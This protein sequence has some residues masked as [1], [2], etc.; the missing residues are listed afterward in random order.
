LGTPPTP[1][2]NG[3]L[4]NGKGICSIFLVINLQSNIVYLSSLKNICVNFIELLRMDVQIA[5]DAF[6]R[7]WI[8]CL[9]GMGA[10]VILADFHFNFHCYDIIWHL[11]F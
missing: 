5:S 4:V 6:L 7:P 9:L 2:K 8:Q 3:K 11:G 10:V 1:Q